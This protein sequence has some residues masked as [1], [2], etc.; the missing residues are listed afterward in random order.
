MTTKYADPTGN[1]ERSCHWNMQ[2]RE[3]FFLS[4]KSVLLLIFLLFKM[5]IRVNQIYKMLTQQ[6]LYKIIF[7]YWCIKIYK[8]FHS[9]VS[10]YNSTTPILSPV[11]ISL[12][13]CPKFSSHTSAY[14]LDNYI[15]IVINISD[16]SLIN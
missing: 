13:Q 11:S 10:D 1:S 7:I 9:K 16:Y 8:I 6:Y 2:Y 5:I 3:N 4:Y 14:L 12:H 15:G